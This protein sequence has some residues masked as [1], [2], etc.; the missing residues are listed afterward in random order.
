V[1]A[2]RARENAFALMALGVFTGLPVPPTL[3]T[4]EL[5]PL[6]EEDLVRLL[7]AAHDAPDRLADTAALFDGF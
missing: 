7:N 4:C 6:L 1:A 3:F 5:F 2:L